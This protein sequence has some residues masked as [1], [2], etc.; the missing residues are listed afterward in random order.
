MCEKNHLDQ[1]ESNKEEKKGYMKMEKLPRHE[2]HQ[3]A[4]LKLQY[5]EI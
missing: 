4:Q 1:K 2:I 3:K 5:M